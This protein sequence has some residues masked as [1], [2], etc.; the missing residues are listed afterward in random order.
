MGSL[1][2]MGNLAFSRLFKRWVAG[3]NARTALRYVERLIGKGCSAT[4]CFLGEHVKSGRKI[5]RH[6]NEF[7]R[8]IPLV[9]E[10]GANAAVTVKP[11]Q[12]GLDHDGD[13]RRGVGVFM[14]NLRE[15]ADVATAHGVHLELDM[16]DRKTTDVTLEAYEREQKRYSNMR[17]CLQANL[18]RTEADLRDLIRLPRAA[19]RLVKGIYLEPDEVAYT[20]EGDKQA[21]FSYLVHLALCTS[22]PDFGLNIGTHHP[23]R[24]REAISLL[25]DHPH[26]RFQ[27]QMLKGV[28]PE[29]ADRLRLD[30]V[31]VGE[32]VPYGREAFAY[33]FRRARK[34]PHFA[35][36][37][38]RSAPPHLRLG[39][40]LMETVYRLRHEHA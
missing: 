31:P 16:E 6:K 25:K 30:G 10:R 9:A 34:N 14:D 37:V 12:I 11:T 40:K 32:Y 2:G 26:D 17:V 38:M 5:A 35:A 33:S 8:L 27:V 39:W 23:E 1:E 22:G 36:M 28:T 15:I 21:N 4:V 19:V 7:L 3:P 18:R 20:N 24:I 13:R 29:L